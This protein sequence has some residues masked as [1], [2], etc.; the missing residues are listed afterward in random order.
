MSEPPAART[1]RRRY[2]TACAL[3]WLPS[4]LAIAPSILLFTERGM[5]L[6]AIAGFI[7]A[8][9]FTAVVLELPTG[10]LSDVLGRRVVL[11]AAGLLNLTAF[12][13]QGLGT[14]PWVLTCGLTL[15]GAARALS[16]G[17]AEAWYVDTVHAHSG[18]DA[19]L[20]TGLARGNTAMS[21]ALAAGT[22]LGGAV[23]WLLTSGPGVGT[24]LSEVTSGLVLPLSIPFLLAACFE[25]VFTVYVLTALREPP[26]PA[27]T[28][29]GV[30]RG[31]PATVAG[32]LRLGARDTLVRRVL[33]SAGAV[34]SAL[35][36]IELLTPGRVAGLTG[37]SESGAVVF[38]ALACAGFLCSALGSHLAP[39]VARL[40]RGGERAVLAGLASSACGVLLLGVTVTSTGATATALAATGYGLVYLGLGA[41]GPNENDLLHRRVPAA[42]RATALSVQS[43]ALQLVGAA[44]GLLVGVLPPGPIPWLLGGTV[45]LAGAFLWLRRGGTGTTT[46]VPPSQ[47]VASPPHV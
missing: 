43:L 28:L 11:A 27:A 5:S 1:A 37:A 25:V 17:P 23:P 6:A 29:R 21:A 41:A 26:R 13:L 36:T 45:L 39:L 40:A 38:A 31:V 46:T 8:H 33:L 35:A 32:G 47:S 24:R 10:G 14:T 42:G 2:V 4:G 19:D 18:P 34:G 20:R 3:F 15:M 7:A 30:L 12:L 22:L 44:T 16:S 9:S